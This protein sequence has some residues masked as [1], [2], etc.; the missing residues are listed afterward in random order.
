MEYEGTVYAATISLLNATTIPLKIHQRMAI[1]QILARVEMSFRKY[2]LWKAYLGV[3][4]AAIY[5]FGNKE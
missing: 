4:P 2:H 5:T 1:K 3:I